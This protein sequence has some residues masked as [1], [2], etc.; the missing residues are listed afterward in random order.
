MNAS[1]WSVQNV[2]DTR[3]LCRRQRRATALR[4]QFVNIVGQYTC[5]LLIANVNGPNRWSDEEVARQLNKERTTI[6][7]C[8][9]AAYARIRR[10]LRF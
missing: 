3:D 1:K 5:D 2:G 6:C 4:K 9:Q 7:R 8:R 10:Q